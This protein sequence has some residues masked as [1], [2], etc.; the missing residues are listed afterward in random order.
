MIHSL[1]ITLRIAV[2]FATRFPPFF[3]FVFSDLRGDQVS[4]TSAAALPCV[5]RE[6]I[7]MISIAASCTLR[8]AEQEP[9]KERAE[10]P[11]LI[12]DSCSASTKKY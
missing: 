7:E 5:V 12:L 1:A 4:E 6:R 11:R 8:C 3:A 9:P 10:E 2:F